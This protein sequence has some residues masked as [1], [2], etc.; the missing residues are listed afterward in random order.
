MQTT[1]AEMLCKAQSSAFSVPA[2][3]VSGTTIGW[4]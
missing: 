3:P 2:D 4:A 1:S